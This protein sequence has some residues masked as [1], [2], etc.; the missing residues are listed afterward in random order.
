MISRYKF[1]RV[2]EDCPDDESPD[3][4]DLSDPEAGE[5]SRTADEHHL[6]GWILTDPLD[7]KERPRVDQDGLSLLVVVRLP[8]ENQTGEAHRFSTVPVGIVI[9]P[10]LIIT[11]CRRGGLVRDHLQL[12]FQR[13]RNW[14]CVR[15]AFA[16]F[17]A[18]GT[19]YILKLERLE[20]LAGE[21]EARLRRSPANEALLVLLDIEKALI[22]ITLALK[23]NHVLMDKFRQDRP[24][25]LDLSKDEKD[26]LDDAVTENQQAVFMA[27]IFGQTLSSMSDAFGS[28]ISN[29]LNKIMKF[30]AGVTIVLM[31]PGIIA[32]L[33]GMNVDLPLAG[34]PG[35]FWLLLG[36]CLGLMLAVSVLFAKKNWF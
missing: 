26:I 7:P 29:N 3:W 21:A 1:S 14:N 25:G 24:F 20:D 15:L 9:S 4:I 32:G 23:S 12:L 28:I 2:I 10:G 8:V 5:L 31:V 16:L 6:P 13:E 34:Q 27:E 22:D 33:Y 11:V 30:M 36:L 17:H 19:G 35:V 18:A